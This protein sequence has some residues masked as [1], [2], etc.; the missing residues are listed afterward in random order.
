MLI[1]TV[2]SKYFGA[3]NKFKLACAINLEISFKYI[4]VA[5]CVISNQERNSK[6]TNTS[7]TVLDRI[8]YLFH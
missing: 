5:R 1:V 2:K 6:Q 7:Q 4:S 8:Q 3:C